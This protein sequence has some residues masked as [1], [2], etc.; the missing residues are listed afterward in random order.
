MCYLLKQMALESVVEKD[1]SGGY[2][3][4]ISGP[5]MQASITGS[6]CTR[7]NGDPPTSTLKLHTTLES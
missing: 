7:G 6:T 2:M 4:S 5:R 1:T 3:I